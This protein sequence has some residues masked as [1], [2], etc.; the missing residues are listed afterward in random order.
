MPIF[1]QYN[2]KGRKSSFSLEEQLYDRSHFSES[3]ELINNL[4]CAQSVLTVGINT[5]QLRP[6]NSS[7]TPWTTNAVA[8]VAPTS[9]QFF[10]DSAGKSLLL[11]T[12]N[13]GKLYKAQKGDANWTEVAASVANTS[14]VLAGGM[15]E[16]FSDDGVSVMLYK[17]SGINTQLRYLTSSALTAVTSVYGSVLGGYDGRGWLSE[18]ST[19]GTGGKSDRVFYT[20]IG[21]Q[22]TVGATSYFQVGTKGYSITS[23]KECKNNYFI[24][25]GSEM[26][27][28]DTYQLSPVFKYGVTPM[29]WS[30]ELGVNSMIDVCN[31]L[32]FA[33]LGNILEYTGEGEPTFISSNDFPNIGEPPRLRKRRDSLLSSY[34]STN[35]A[36]IFNTIT[37][38]GIELG[39]GNASYELGFRFPTIIEN[40]DADNDTEG[41]MAFIRGYAIKTDEAQAYLLDGGNAYDVFAT[42]ANTFSPYFNSMPIIGN[43]PDEAPLTKAWK[44]LDVYYEGDVDVYFKTEHVSS[45]TK[46]PAGVKDIDTTMTRFKLPD[47]LQS[48]KIELQFWPKTSM[49]YF[50]GFDLN[51]DLKPFEYGF[52]GQ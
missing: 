47:S 20:D 33:Y 30:V 11:M 17:N 39:H 28:W 9:L 27:K 21:D 51:Y 46:L 45:W 19:A 12:G 16:T 50:K 10:K 41:V 24:A 43:T 34:Q 26:Y 31:E 18:F 6:R 40:E 44:I 49:K 13:D 36:Y 38:E 15:Y 22:D 1:R 8:S 25:N 37:H 23:M 4:L 35:F 7:N 5:G 52:R 3:A 48:K 32:Y 29:S 2:F 42:S 14:N